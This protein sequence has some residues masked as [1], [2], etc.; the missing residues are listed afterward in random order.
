MMEIQ[1]HQ[2]VCVSS[3]HL[4]Y[5]HVEIESLEWMDNFFIVCTC[6]LEGST[7]TDCTSSECSCKPEYTGSS[8]DMCNTDHYNTG[9]ASQSPPTC[10]R[11]YISNITIACKG[12]LWPYLFGF[13]IPMSG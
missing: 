9:G 2:L 6:Y 4:L 3:T 8:C 5:A 10:G 13:E 7:T 1:L 12:S 11:K